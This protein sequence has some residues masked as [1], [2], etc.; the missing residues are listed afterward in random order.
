MNLLATIGYPL[1]GVATLN[2][3]LGVFLLS[4]RRRDPLRP[5]AAAMACINAAY[6]AVIG[7]AYVRASLGIDFNFFYRCAW[8]G[9]VALAPLLQMTFVIQGKPRKALVWGVASY[10]IWGAI[11]VTCLTTDLVEVG[12]ISLVPFADHAGPFEQP[13]RALGAFMIGY[14]LFEMYRAH[15][16]SSGRRRQQTAYLLLG[17]AIYGAA[18]AFFAGIAQITGAVRFDPGL[19]GYFSLA[20]MALTFYAVHRHRLFDIRFVLSRAMEALVLSALLATTVIVLFRVMV[21][22]VGA[23]T[24]VTLS[25]L[26]AAFIFFMTPLVVGV[27]RL[28]DRLFVRHRYDYQQAL[29]DSVQA[30]AARVR[31]EEVCQQLLGVTR[32][33]LGARAA[34]I[35]VSTEAGFRVAHAYGIAQGGT[36]PADSALVRRLGQERVF[37]RDE[38][39]GE[40]PEEEMAVI[41]G[42]LRTFG[43]EVA[44]PIRYQQTLSGI[45]LLGG[46]LDR[47]AY[48][49][50]DVDLLET[51]ATE[52]GIALANA[53]LLE[54]R[55]QSIRLRDEFL[56]IA[57][58]ELRTPLTALQLNVQSLLSPPP[59]DERAHTRLTRT[60]RQ[61]A[62]LERLTNELL[63]VS[64]IT[65]GRLKLEREWVDLAALAQE[66]ASRYADELRKSGVEFS[67][68]AP[69]AVPGCWDRV[70]VEQ[71]LSNLVSNA[72]KYGQGTPISVRIE[73][74][75]DHA[76]ITVQDRG[77]GISQ[78][79]QARIFERFE[80]AVSHHHAGGFGLGLWITKQV[81]EAHGGAISVDSAPHQ[82]TRFTVELPTGAAKA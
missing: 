17:M 2:L 5:Y 23:A 4:S 34:A 46:K 10:A 74:A 30:L 35:L 26:V 15:R 12:V 49:Q 67:L 77:M 16:D 24:A 79:D 28:T 6:C 42:E 64:R 37:V 68:E 41:D 29:R 60:E 75:G 54:E 62:R 3:L 66:V 14:A 47:D 50:V 40:L 20:W 59:A 69:G 57:G 52:A 56:A 76:R 7:I 48:L 43:A 65:A 81:V 55:E 38:Q 51:L 18:G 78:T 39:A 13:A 9:W 31:V 25:S 82:G 44:V 80:R 71:V 27:Q 32:D 63:D 11:L 1:L 61:I 21:F 45:L 22:D 36:L 19:V 58:H 70:R 33:T 53:S 8:V 73:P 72:I